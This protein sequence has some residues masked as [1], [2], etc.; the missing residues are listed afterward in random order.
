M[1]F[2]FFAIIGLIVAATPRSSDAATSKVS[3]S[4][5]QSSVKCRYVAGEDICQTTNGHSTYSLLQVSGVGFKPYLGA[6]VTIIDMT[7]MTFR[8]MGIVPTDANGKFLLRTDDIE[9]CSSGGGR[10]LQVQA[11][12]PTGQNKSNTALVMECA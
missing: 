10:L 1:L 3:V 8:Y 9:V 6:Y 5:Y 2:A 11:S 4:T 7:T 12:D